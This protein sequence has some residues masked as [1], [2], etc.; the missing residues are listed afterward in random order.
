MVARAAGQTSDTSD[1]DLARRIS[2]GKYGR[3]G[4]KKE[5]WSRPARKLLSRDKGGPGASDSEPS[6]HH[7]ATPTAA[8]E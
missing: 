1:D 7:P 4:S 5:R 8:I 3:K 2:S 6:Y